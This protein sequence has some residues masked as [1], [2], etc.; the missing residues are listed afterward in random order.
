MKYKENNIKL[1]FNFNNCLISRF[2][3]LLANE[4]TNQLK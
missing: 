2:Y 3:N 4:K 1:K